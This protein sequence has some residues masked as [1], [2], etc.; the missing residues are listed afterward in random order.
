MV[1]VSPTWHWSGQGHQHFDFLFYEILEH[2]FFIYNEKLSLLF[3]FQI[4][5]KEEKQ[6]ALVICQPTFVL[7]L[8]SFRNSDEKSEK[9]IAV[10]FIKYNIYI[11]TD[12]LY[13]NSL[14]TWIYN[15]ELLV[16][17]I[18]YSNC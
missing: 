3:C 15:T 10:R 5:Y 14:K 9:I 6:G 8:A 13:G 4:T 12:T 1:T 17:I 18:A 7:K 16:M 11:A 2:L